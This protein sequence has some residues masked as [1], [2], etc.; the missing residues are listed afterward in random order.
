MYLSRVAAEK[1]R[2]LRG[3]DCR[4]KENDREQAR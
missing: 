3:L 4:L 2:T 1:V